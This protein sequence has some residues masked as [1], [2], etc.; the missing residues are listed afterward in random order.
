MNNV[1]TTSA[2]KSLFRTSGTATA[3]ITPEFANVT[4]RCARRALRL[5]DKVANL[6]VQSEYSVFR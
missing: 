2:F 6:R 5:R 1:I 4:P 3:D